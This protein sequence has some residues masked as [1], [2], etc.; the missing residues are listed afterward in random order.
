MRKYLRETD[1]IH[2]I[3]N[4]DSTDGMSELESRIFGNICKAV[5]A[6]TV[7]TCICGDSTKRVQPA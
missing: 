3:G 5:S 2:A 4:A 1:V 6:L 7:F